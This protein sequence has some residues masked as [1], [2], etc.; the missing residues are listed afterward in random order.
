M[1]SSKLEAPPSRLARLPFYYGWVNV[2]I[3]SLAMSATLPGRTH[4]LGLITTP[5]LADPMLRLDES[6]YSALNMWAV[7]LGALLCYPVG[8]FIDRFG[9]RAVLT[10]VSLALGAAVVAM[11]RATEPAT[12]FVSLTLV[13]GLG[14][15]ALTVT[16]MAIV[17]KWFTRRLGL[18]MGVFTFL[19]AFGFI[20]GVLGT[21]EAV[22][23]YGWRIAWCGVGVALILGL[24]PLGA[25]LVR[26]QPES[27]GAPVD[28]TPSVA[29]EAP[30][31]LPLMQALRHPAFWAFT[32]ATS[33]FNLVWSAITL[34]NARILEEN[35]FDEKTFL[36][37]M[38]VLTA[39]G[40][41]AN[42]LCGWLAGRWPM[43]RLLAFG[44]FLFAGSLL[45]AP[46]LSSI[47][48]V[49]AYSALL[50][51]SGGI[52]TVIF[53]SV[54]GHA[55]GR[56]HFGAIQSTV[57]VITVLASAIGP[58]ILTGTKVQTGSYALFFYWAAPFAIVLG[59]AAWEAP[60]PRSREE[61]ER[62]R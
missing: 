16:S 42:I 25:L 40:L 57:Q 30:L 17:G 28:A 60:L 11:S 3:A 4:G 35:G 32:L 62:E 43:G 8:W 13:R 51:V 58:V 7:V 15:G 56:A 53:F 33:L 54:Y 38:T 21:G 49:I 59:I 5:L 39:A 9:V 50:G 10:V 36:L 22:Q 27:I 18:A 31:E 26:D 19:L 41:P 37:A 23:A 12:L 29:A 14:Q 2:T 55:F 20:A 34:F 44:M 47:S 45:M 46:T 6:T 61:T 24:A 52:I 48:Q 1:W